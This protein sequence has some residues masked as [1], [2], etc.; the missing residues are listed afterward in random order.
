MH[1]RMSNYASN[2]QRE[3]SW[4]VLLKILHRQAY[5]IKTDAHKFDGQDSLE[6]RKQGL[7]FKFLICLVWRLSQ[8]P[9]LAM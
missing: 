6:I 2:Q 5:S 3:T 4:K 9:S 7:V 1:P 8:T